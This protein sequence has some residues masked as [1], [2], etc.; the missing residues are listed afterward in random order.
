[1][2]KMGKVFP[3]R[4]VQVDAS[5]GYAIVIADAL[6]EQL[7]T[8]HQGIKTAMRWTGA[9]ERTVKNWF[10][11]TNGPCGEHLIAL[12]RHSEGVLNAVMVMAGRPSA[13]AGAKLASLEEKVAEFHNF[14][15]AV[16]GGG[17]SRFH[18]D[19]RD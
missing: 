18:G 5:A 9:S 11:G 8:S 10:A 15:G 4:N 2:P 13:I 16:L 19:Q 6:Q 14:L 17:D 12:V 1:L 3:G 7:G